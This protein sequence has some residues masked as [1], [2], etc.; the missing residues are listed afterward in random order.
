MA[1]SK[2][3][4]NKYC[5]Q[6]ELQHPV[7]V[8]VLPLRA[9]AI[10][11]ARKYARLQVAEVRRE[12]AKV[13]N[14]LKKAAPWSGGMDGY[15]RYSL[16]TRLTKWRKSSIT[17]HEPCLV[18]VKTALVSRFLRD[19]GEAAADQYDRFV[20]KMIDKVGPAKKAVL[21]GNHVWG[22]SYLTVTKRDGAIE[23]WHT[24]QITNVSKLG[25]HFPQW[26]SRKVKNKQTYD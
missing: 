7:A 1:P 15:E 14:D 21:E 17:G 3:T 6:A 13:G 16:F 24:R 11:F 9:D 25:L 22:Y 20:K 2:S 18:D 8:A 10:K 19:A 23:I 4:P 26:P 12:L 5:S